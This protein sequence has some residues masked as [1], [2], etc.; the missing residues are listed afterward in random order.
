VRERDELEGVGR[1]DPPSTRIVAGETA[2][3]VSVIS[4]RRRVMNSSA[5]RKLPLS[6]AQP[7]PTCVAVG[8]RIVRRCPSSGGVS[9]IISPCDLSASSF[10]PIWNSF[11]E[12]TQI[13][14]FSDPTPKRPANAVRAY[15]GRP[16]MRKW[17]RVRSRTCA[18]QNRRAARAVPSSHATA[19]RP[20][21]WRSALMRSNTDRST[22]SSGSASRRSGKDSR[23]G[24]V[25]LGSRTE[26]PAVS[27]TPEPVAQAI[28]VA[29]A[30]QAAVR[31][32]RVTFTG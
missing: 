31:R 4:A 13:A 22:A 2:T 30:V 14:E 32:S 29:A 21:A 15:G 26:N 24:W 7:T 19:D 3:R 25:R 16:S 17:P 8:S 28:A 20:A 23:S 6:C 10:M 11:A 9:S 27:W 12:L 5:M 18:A 1:Q